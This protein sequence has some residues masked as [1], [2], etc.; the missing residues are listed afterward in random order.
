M[1]TLQEIL[2]EPQTMYNGGLVAMQ[3][4]GDLGD[5]F[6]KLRAKTTYLRKIL[7][8][9]PQ[10]T[11]EIP[12]QDGGF[13]VETYVNPETRSEM[14]IPH[15]GNVPSW[16]V[17]P[18]FMLKSEI[19]DQLI[20]ADPP[21][22]GG[23]E[24]VEGDEIGD[25]PGWD[26]DPVDHAIDDLNAQLERGVPPDQLDLTDAMSK[27]QV[28]QSQIHSRVAQTQTLLSV[29]P[30]VITAN[31]VLKLAWAFM[32]NFLTP[33]L[34]PD[35]VGMG[36]TSGGP[37]GDYGMGP[38]PDHAAGDPGKAFDDYTDTPA[39]EVG[40]GPHGVHGGLPGTPTSALD[41][42][43]SWP[44]PVSPVDD[45]AD[46]GPGDPGDMG[47]GPGTGDPG[48]D[49]WARGGLVRPMYDGGLV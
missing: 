5:I 30:S 16:P 43:S 44:S 27:N 31:P 28:T 19:T 25:I 20:A 4:G 9:M 47:H 11:D 36:V 15:M 49:P 7:E 35:M 14:K 2:T 29:L 12:M 8:S 17:P 37:G 38:D 26:K 39:D 18:G 3:D 32:T 40:A 22:P 34:T 1:H 42:L 21:A 41:N 48:A 46:T 13:V 33:G 23:L 24:A 10:F 45:A 6:K